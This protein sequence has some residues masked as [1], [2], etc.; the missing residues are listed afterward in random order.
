[1]RTF[2]YDKTKEEITISEIV[3]TL[4]KVDAVVYKNQLVNAQKQKDEAQLLID[5][6][7]AALGIIIVK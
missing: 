1:M 5:E 3:T 4:T 7:K 2:T 6:A